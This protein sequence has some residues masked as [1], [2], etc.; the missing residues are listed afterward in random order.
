MLDELPRG[1]T[2]KILRR[3]LQATSPRRTENDLRHRRRYPLLRAVA[4][5]VERRQRRAPARPRGLRHA[6]RCSSFGWPTGEAAP[7]VAGA[8]MLDAA[9]RGL[10]GDFAGRRGRIALGAD[11]DC[12]GRLLGFVYRRELAVP[13]LLRGATARHPRRRLRRRSPP[14]SAGAGRTACSA[15]RGPDAGTS[16][17]TNVVRY[18]PHR[19]NVAD[20]WR[21]A[22]LPA[23][24]PRPRA[25]AGARRGVGDRDAPTA[26]LPADGRAGRTRLDLRLDGLPGQSAQHLAR[27]HR[28][29]QAGAGVGQ[30]EHRRL[31]RR[32]RLRGDH[33]RFRGRPPDRAGGADAERSA[34]ATGFRGRR[35][36]GGGRGADLRP[37]RLVHR[38][39]LGQARVHRDPAALHRQEAVRRAPRRVPRRVADH[40]GAA[41]RP[42]VLRAAR[43]RRLDHPGAGGPRRSPRRSRR[44]R[45]IPLSTP[46]FRTRSTPST[47]SAHRTGTSPRRPSRTSWTG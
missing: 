5:L 19:A 4:E 6:S 8:S 10:R 34:V 36:V 45:T 1:S 28:R 31:R 26:G 21:R 47:S 17:R 3:D 27:P 14:R 24:R 39:G 35:H 44:R 11:G 30:G 12:A 18:G 23:R 15:R 43:H 13:G 40:Q 7:V 20:V 37:L 33:R 29:R 16:R 2:G 38:G 25:A 42:A 32:P 9:R 22:D 41:G 46:R